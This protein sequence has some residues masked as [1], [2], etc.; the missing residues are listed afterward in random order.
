M[1]TFTQY[2]PVLDVRGIPLDY[3]RSHGQVALSRSIVFDSDYPT[4]R[5]Y[6]WC[7]PLAIALAGRRLRPSRNMVIVFSRFASR[8]LGT[9]ITVCSLPCR[10]CFGSLLS[11]KQSLS[12]VNNVL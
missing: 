3:D 12:S 9:S 8:W 2:G 11:W 6:I 10:T 4:F 1:Q 5:Y 7:T